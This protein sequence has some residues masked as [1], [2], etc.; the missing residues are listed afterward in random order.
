MPSYFS[1][2]LIKGKKMLYSHKT[3]LDI[4]VVRVLRY[5]LCTI[6]IHIVG[7]LSVISHLI[8]ID[9]NK[10]MSIIRIQTRNAFYVKK[11]S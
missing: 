5:T 7:V 4:Y 9:N 2:V 1:I 3:T 10:K 6:S 11:Y 8:E